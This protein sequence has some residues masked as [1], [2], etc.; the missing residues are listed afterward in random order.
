MRNL[1]I[2]GDILLFL[3]KHMV[4]LGKAGRIIF[5]RSGNIGDLL[6]ITP[7]IVKVKEK[8]PEIN[9]SVLV[10]R[11]N[12]QIVEDNPYIDKIF[13]Y[14]KYKHGF[15]KSRVE[16]YLNA[17]RLFLNI[18]KERYDIAIGC[19]AVYSKRIARMTY[20]TGAGTRIGYVPE[21]GLLPWLFYNV[22]IPQMSDGF[23]EVEYI[24]NIIK[25][26]LGI[27]GEPGRLIIKVPEIE[28][29]KA[30]R[31]MFENF[32]DLKNRK[33]VAIHISSRG[34]RNRWSEE[35]FSE[36]INM[37]KRRND[38][39]IV[40]LWFPGDERNPFYPGDDKKAEKI[41][42]MV[43]NKIIRYPT[44]TVK[45]LIGILSICNYLICCDSGTLHIGAALQIPTVGLFRSTKYRKW[46]PWK[47]KHRSIKKGDTLEAID[48]EDVISA[49]EDLRKECE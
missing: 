2:S 29:E 49:F 14:D 6:C 20:F 16:A 36:L 47:T 10:N 8:N 22:P 19:S 48:P 28:R 13:I 32:P 35:K 17:L 41:Y 39:E 33:F 3:S 30:N 11:Y 45:E 4:S 5:V 42:K 44:L 1:N 12:Y 25:R 27:E 40:L 46:Y 9:V 23:H 26:G 31:Y 7:S 38:V 43:R 24:F 21:K 37:I 15:Y 34:P 18:R